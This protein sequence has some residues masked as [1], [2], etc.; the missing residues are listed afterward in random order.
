MA[1]VLGGEEGKGQGHRCVVAGDEVKK[2][3]RAAGGVQGG[4]KERDERDERR[5]RRTAPER[6]PHTAEEAARPAAS[7]LIC[8]AFMPCPRNAR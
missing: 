2:E 7:R 8:A 3:E 6:L 4:K 5:E 1:F